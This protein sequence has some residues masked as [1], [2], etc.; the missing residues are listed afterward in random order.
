MLCLSYLTGCSRDCK[1]LM[2]ICAYNLGVLWRSRNVGFASNRLGK[3]G[4]L[5]YLALHPA[6][7]LGFTPR[8]LSTCLFFSMM[9]ILSPSETR[10]LYPLLSPLCSFRLGLTWNQSSVWM[11]FSYFLW[12]GL[13]LFFGIGTS[14]PPVRTLPDVSKTEEL[15]SFKIPMKI[16]RSKRGLSVLSF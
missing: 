1:H 7:S 9:W 3:D 16:P 4:F 10:L 6:R 13:N 12:R 8:S 5:S 11:Y 15:V 2:S 14:V